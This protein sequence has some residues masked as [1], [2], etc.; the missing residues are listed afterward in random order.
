MKYSEIH[1]AELVFKFLSSRC[2]KKSQKAW[3]ETILIQDFQLIHIIF[4]K[5]T[6]YSTKPIFYIKTKQIIQNAKKSKIHWKTSDT[7]GVARSQCSIIATKLKEQSAEWRVKGTKLHT[8]LSDSR[9]SQGFGIT[10]GV[11]LGLIMSDNRN[12]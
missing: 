2:H 3:T 9:N 1:E 11:T 12:L 5:D 4:S 7:F 10:S 8:Y 6:F